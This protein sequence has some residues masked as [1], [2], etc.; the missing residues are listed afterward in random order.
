MKKILITGASGFIGSHLVEYLIKDGVKP[1]EIRLLVPSWEKYIDPEFKIKDIVIG[2]IR[3]KKT[4]DVVMR[5]VEI[6]YHL[7]SKTGYDGGSYEYFKDTNVDGTGNILE[8][9]KKQNVKKFIFFSSSGVY[10]LPATAGDIRNY[11][12]KKS[13]TYSEGYGQSKY[14]AEN[15]ILNASKEWGLN[16]IILR[17]TTVYGPRDKGGL[18]QLIKA[19]NKGYFFFIGNGKNKMDYVYVYDVVRTARVLEKSKIVNEDF[20]V[21]SGEPISLNNMVKVICEKLGKTSPNIHVSKNLALFLSFVVKYF[22]KLIGVRPVF[23]PNRVRVISSDF[24]F[25]ISKIKKAIKYKPKFSFE[26]GVEETTAWLEK[27]KLI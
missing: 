19:I 5:G 15:L 10:G 20:I 11:N 22:S 7:A 9:A 24:Y 18:L 27:E 23:F 25:D 6:I 12:E 8:A 1:E 16:Y 3:D 21:G 14:E 2:D 17:P 4:V 26:Q 13:R